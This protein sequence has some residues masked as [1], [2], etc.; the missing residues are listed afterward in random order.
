[1]KKEMQEVIVPVVKW[2]QYGRWDPEGLYVYGMLGSV[3]YTHPEVARQR[4][5]TRSPFLDLNDIPKL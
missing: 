3:I 2:T 1:M 4:N 5:A